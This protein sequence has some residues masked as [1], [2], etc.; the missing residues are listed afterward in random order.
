MTVNAVV[1]STL[2]TVANRD[3]GRPEEVATWVRPESVAEA[4]LWLASDLAAD[5]TGA[6]VPVYG[7]T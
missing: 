6:L 4:I 3:W 1:P 7:R 5:V 2:N